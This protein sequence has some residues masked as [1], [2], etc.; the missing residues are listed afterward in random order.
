MTKAIPDLKMKVIKK[1]SRT[2][3]EIKMKLKNLVTQLENWK[4][5][6]VSKIN[7]GKTDCQNVK[8]Q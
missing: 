3:A 6:L 7:Q 4:E 5:I 8:I 1:Y 2:Q